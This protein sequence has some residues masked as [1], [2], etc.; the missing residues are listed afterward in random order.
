M[1]S[2]KNRQ[3]R[4]ANRPEGKPKA[5]DFELVEAD[6]P[7]LKDGE[8]LIQTLYLSVDPGMRNMM[9]DQKSY[10]A[11]FGLHEVL[12]GRSVGKVI[13]SKNKN[14]AK[15]DAVFERLGWQDYSISNGQA[16]KKIDLEIAPAS[17]YLGVL[18][19][20]GLVA[21]FGYSEIALPK[22][23]ETVVVSGAS[24]AV[25]MNAGQ[26]AK[27][28]GCRVVGIAGSDEKN[29]YLTEE[30][31]FDEAINYKTT[32]DMK[33]ALEK[34]CPDGIDIYFDNV[35]GEITDAALQ[36]INY[37]ARVV[38]SGQTSQYNEEKPD[39]GPRFLNQL[40]TKSAMIKGFVVYDYEDKNDEAI[41]QMAKWI[42]DGQLKYKENVVDGLEN[43]PQ[44]F[45]DLFESKSFGKQVVKVSE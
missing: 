21:Y 44:A 29:R 33:A 17:A 4:L 19:V 14:F 41:E 45:I 39:E 26:I 27:I 11:P 35:G 10:T 36:L 7:E 42:R 6:V 9:K 3:I 43:A 18:G 28:H 8:I 30:L 37:H 20:P 34:A 2:L 5:S 13:E 38:I 25:G 22:K 16:T 12:T 24:G 31:G 32:K 15:G 40:V 23:G 1:K